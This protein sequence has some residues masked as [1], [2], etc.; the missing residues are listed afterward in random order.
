MTVS[1][2]LRYAALPDVATGANARSS[3]FMAFAVALLPN[4]AFLA[5]SPWYMAARPVAPLTYILAGIVALFAPRWLG[6]AAFILAAAFD[7]MV[8]IMHAFHMPFA[9]ALDSMRFMSSL[10]LT[11]SL[12]YISISLVVIASSATAAWIVVKHRKSFRTASCLPAL[13]IAAAITWGDWTFTYPYAAKSAPAFSSAMKQTGLNPE[14]IVAGRKN[15]LV[16]MVEGLGAIAKPEMRALFENALSANLPEGRYRLTTGVSPYAGSTTGATSRELCGQWGSYLTYLGKGKFRCLPRRLAEQG[17]ETIAY[18]G[19][20]FHMFQRDLWYPSI[21]FTELNFLD[22]LVKDHE[23][24]LTGRCGT[25]FTGLCDVE[26]AHVVRDR[27]LQNN[28]KPKMVYW[29]T[30]NS[31]IPYAPKRNGALRCG[32]AGAEIANKT[33]CELSEFWLDVFAQVNRIAAAPSLPPTDILVVG[34]HHTPLWEREAN[35]HFI[36]QKV[37]WFL[38]RDQRKPAARTSP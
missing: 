10:D 26:V 9:V 23:H 31:H 5:V 21:G 28:G 2:A 30:L 4:I 35:N 38:L 33:A 13:T 27:L 19:R 18:H 12:L 34:D 11:A 22:Q 8:I 25:V 17:Y 24:Q 29:L 32:T 6:W 7:L 20:P 3:V 36:L 14:A 1:K 37:D 16:V 15:L